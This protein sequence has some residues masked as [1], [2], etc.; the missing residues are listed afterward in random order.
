LL[1]DFDDYEIGDAEQ[2][3]SDAAPGDKASRKKRKTR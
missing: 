1:S 2:S 3:D